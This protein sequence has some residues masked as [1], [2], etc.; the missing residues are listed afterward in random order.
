MANKGYTVSNKETGVEED[1]ALVDAIKLLNSGEFNNSLNLQLSINMIQ[2]R[3]RIGWNR[4]FD[5]AVVL[6]DRGLLTNH[7]IDEDIDKEP[8]SELRRD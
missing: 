2:R 1:E 3:F 5:L 6:R 4:A 7:S 8:R